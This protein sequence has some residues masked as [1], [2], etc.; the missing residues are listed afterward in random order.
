M[1]PGI[2]VRG[3]RSARCVPGRAAGAARTSPGAR[4]ARCA[5]VPVPVAEPGGAQVLPAPRDVSDRR[6]PLRHRGRA[7]I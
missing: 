2:P 4:P 3:S 1:G 7:A 5:A 6:R